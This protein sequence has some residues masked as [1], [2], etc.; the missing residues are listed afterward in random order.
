ML[1]CLNQLHVLCCY[2]PTAGASDAEKE[3]FYGNLAHLLD[4]IPP[5]K[6]FLVCGD[7]NAT[8]TQ[9]ISHVNFLPG[10]AANHNSELFTEFLLSRQLRPANFYQQP[11]RIHSMVPTR[12]EYVST[13][14][15]Y[16][17]DGFAP[18]GRPRCYTALDLSS[19]TT[20]Q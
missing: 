13:T 11:R 20:E 14:F 10:D 2:T 12:E 15:S 16:R 8:M 5:D 6:K 19:Q 3:E 1:L 17:L 4:A 9:S 18:S 7:F